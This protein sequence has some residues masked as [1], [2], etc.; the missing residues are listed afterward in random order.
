MC[1]DV[2]ERYFTYR[3]FSVHLTVLAELEQKAVKPAIGQN[4]FFRSFW[5]SNVSE[6]DRHARTQLDDEV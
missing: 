4:F 1:P 6:I 3:D 5:D 2:L